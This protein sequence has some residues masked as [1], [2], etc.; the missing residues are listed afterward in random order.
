MN[1]RIVA[2][3]DAF[4]AM[5]SNRPYQPP[6][7]KKEAFRQL[8]QGAGEF[9]EAEFIAVFVAMGDGLDEIIG[10]GRALS[11]DVG[12]VAL[13]ERDREEPSSPKTRKPAVL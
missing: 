11:V 4:D 7:P 1:A 5:T 13:A 8:R 9:F 12:T 3:A 2:V 10:Q 6:L